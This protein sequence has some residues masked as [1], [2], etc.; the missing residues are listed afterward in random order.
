MCLW[1]FKKHCIKA[2]KFSQTSELNGLYRKPSANSVT[3]LTFSLANYKLNG[4]WIKAAAGLRS[5]GTVTALCHFVHFIVPS[6]GRKWHPQPNNSH[7]IYTIT[8]SHYRQVLF[9]GVW[10]EVAH[11][12]CTFSTL[13][14]KKSVLWMNIKCNWLNLHISW[15]VIDITCDTVICEMIK[16]LM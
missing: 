2:D 7:T 1:Q 15:H 16:L 13:W 6:N 5:E 8:Q 10:V 12:V 14:Q 4:C 11:S 9:S 3:Q